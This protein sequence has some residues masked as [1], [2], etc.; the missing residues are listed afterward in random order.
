MSL[1]GMFA[2]DPAAS[3]PESSSGAT[4]QH[5]VIARKYRPKTFGELVGQE[6]IWRGLSGAI[7]ANRVGHAY[8]FTGARGTGKTTTAR[9]F[10]KCLNCLQTP[11]ASIEPCGVCD[12]CRGVD[13][14]N[15]I[16]V[17]E[18]DAAST[19]GVDDVRELRQN[20]IVR[21]TR[22]RYKIYILDEAHMM[23]KSAFNALLKTLEEPPAHVKFIFCTTEAEKIPITILSRCQRFDFAHVQ[24]QKIAERLDLIAKTEQVAVEPAALALLARRAGG[25]MRDS[26]SLLEQLLAFGSKQ[27]TAN[28]V[29]QMLG[30]TDGSRLIELIT[31]IA[32]QDAPR[33]LQVLATALAAGADLGTFWDQLLGILRDQLVL[34][35]GADEE[36]LLHSVPGDVPVLKELSQRIGLEGIMAWMQ[37]VDQTLGRLRY[38]N[39]PRTLVELAIVR[40]CRVGELQTV[41]QLVGALRQGN[42]GQLTLQLP[43]VGSVPV[44]AATPQAPMT[45]ANPA[46]I[47]T[48]AETVKKNEIADA[49]NTSAAHDVINESLPVVAAIITAETTAIPVVAEQPKA[50]AQS[51]STAELLTIWQNLLNESTD[52][53][54]ESARMAEARI[55]TGNQAGSGDN[56]NFAPIQLALNFQKRYNFHKQ[57]CERAGA[58]NGLA[59]AMG[60]LTGRKVLFQF[61]LC[62]NPAETANPAPTVQPVAEQR[63][64]QQNRMHHPFVKKVMEQFQARLLRVEEPN[65]AT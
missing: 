43:S 57:C 25:S 8:L 39:Q 31:A 11:S 6:H 23:S 46:A 52:L 32:S 12:S 13:A 34:A 27:I 64:Q 28:D 29:H 1:P 24:S 47:S 65:S 59:V 16:D 33:A 58:M 14:G 48:S 7:H 45:S 2:D 4:K 35:I 54:A 36:L 17:I 38:L 61:T 20:A 18:M 56:A 40:M 51:L 9:I 55:S 5:E 22:A 50:P 19:N 63:Q 60:E 26:Q 21:P 37:I 3:E 30:T 62:E 49:P 53:I 42:L 44:A 41:A 15:D 10:A